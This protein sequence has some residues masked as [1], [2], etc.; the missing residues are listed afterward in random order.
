MSDFNTICK[1][2]AEIYTLN[3]DEG[4]YEEFCQFNDIGVPLAY[5]VNENLAI[6]SDDG[7]KMII[8]SW[9]ILLKTLEIDDEGF[10]SLDEVLA[11]AE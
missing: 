8:G 1:I 3:S 4:L 11:W 6:P 2:L 7:K 5:F 9:D 10:G